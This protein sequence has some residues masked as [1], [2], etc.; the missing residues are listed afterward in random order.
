MVAVGRVEA[1][2]CVCPQRWPPPYE[3]IARPD[4]TTEQQTILSKKLEFR[5]YDLNNMGKLQKANLIKQIRLF[6]WA[7]SHTK[8]LN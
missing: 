5:N 2:P 8:M 4:V 1:D 7:L 6:L 3:R